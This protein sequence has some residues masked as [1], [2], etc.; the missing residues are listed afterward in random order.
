MY[1]C[2]ELSVLQPR[3]PSSGNSPTARK[4]VYPWVKSGAGFGSF[5]QRASWNVPQFWGRQ[6]KRDIFFSVSDSD[7]ASTSLLVYLGGLLAV[8]RKAVC[9]CL[10]KK[11]NL[12]LNILKYLL[13]CEEGFCFF[14]FHSAS[15]KKH[16]CSLA[17]S[18]DVD[19][20]CHFTVGLVQLL[21]ANS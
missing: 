9:F 21:W 7:T 15:G 14:S 11:I 8:H 1:D 5:T 12:L 2:P 16:F 18:R 19:I 10:F 20:N 4:T 13:P 17:S 3:A 6:R